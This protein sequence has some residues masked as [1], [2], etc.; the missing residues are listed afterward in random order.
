MIKGQDGGILL[1][2]V[3]LSEKIAKNDRILTKGDI[4]EGGSGFPP[5]LIVGRITSVNKRASDLFQTAEV[6]SLV[7]FERLSTVFIMVDN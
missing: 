1:D 7:D 3:V 2:H 4:D 5:D 6:K